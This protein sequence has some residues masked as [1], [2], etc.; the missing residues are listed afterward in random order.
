MIPDQKL[1]EQLMDSKSAI[2]RSAAKK[3]RKIG[4]PFAG[5]NLLVALEKEV[6]NRKTWETQYQ[7]IMA[8]GYCGYRESFSFLESLSKKENVGMVQMALGNSLFRLSHVSNSIEKVIDFIEENDHYLVC[9]ALQVIAEEKIIPSSNEIDLIIDY[10]YSLSSDYAEC[11][12][13]VW[14]L[15]SFPGWPIEKVDP[16]IDH[17]SSNSYPEQRLI[18]E[19][20]EFARQRE[21]R[22][23]AIL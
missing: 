11:T 17:F 5:S 4:D 23:W 7:M 1:F 10:G 2:R 6:K 15:R 16:L 19:S 21:Y 14:L 20:L 8:L 22:S 12:C 9:G 3:L 18:D 13:A